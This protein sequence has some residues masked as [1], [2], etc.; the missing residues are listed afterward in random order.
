MSQ[1]NVE[2]W[3]VNIEAQLAELTAGTSPEATIS[4]LAEIWDPEIELD[5]TDAPALD[6]NGFYRGADAVRQ[7]WQEWFSAC[8][9]PSSSSTSWSMPGSAWSCC[10]TSACGALQG[11]E[12]PFGKFAGSARSGTD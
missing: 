2:I 11:I 3:R 1:Q 12:V 9:R 10:W 8:G 4:K 7:F 6:L 5:T